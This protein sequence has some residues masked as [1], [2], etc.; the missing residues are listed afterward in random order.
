MTPGRYNVLTL[1]LALVLIAPSVSPAADDEYPPSIR[2]IKERGKL[3]VLCLDEDSFPVVM[4][5]ALG[6]R[7]GL[8]IDLGKQI[9]EALGVDVVFDSSTPSTSQMIQR[10]LLGEGDIA[11]GLGITPQRAQKV[12]FSKPYIVE[13]F[14]LLVNRLVLARLKSNDA[15]ETLKA[16]L[17][18]IVCREDTIFETFA[19]RVFPAATLHTTGKTSEAYERLLAGQ[20][21]AMPLDELEAACYLWQ[22]PGDVLTLLLQPLPEHP[23]LAGIAV[24][25][26]NLHLAAWLDVLLETSGHDPSP[27]AINDRY[28]PDWKR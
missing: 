4:T 11:M 27:D 22:H 20:A 19:R 28:L 6:K 9:A 2:R 13:H 18:D 1:V 26:D 12:L 10:L 14:A 5:D 17:G 24:A 3:V 23:L 8:D 16:G 25:P 21:L 15:A 7:R